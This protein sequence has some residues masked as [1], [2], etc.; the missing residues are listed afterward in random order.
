M[1]QPRSSHTSCPP[2]NLPASG[3][4]SDPGSDRHTAAIPPTTTRD[5]PVVWESTCTGGEPAGQIPV[6]RTG[7]DVPP[8]GTG[9][10]TRA[11]ECRASPS[12]RPPKQIERIAAGV[13]GCV[14]GASGVARRVFPLISC[15]AQCSETAAAA[16]GQ[17]FF[18]AQSI[19]NSKDRM[20]SSC[21]WIGQCGEISFLSQQV[22]KVNSLNVAYSDAMLESVRPFHC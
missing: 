22:K 19:R 3:S 13:E 5:Q 4:V 11:A 18:L 2:P 12:A 16:G 21:R 17:K 14:R 20:F 7:S 15:L 10:A 9:R 8:S 6:G 1:P